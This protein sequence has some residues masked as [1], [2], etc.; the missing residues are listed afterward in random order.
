MSDAIFI[1]MSRDVKKL[2]ER[3]P[4]TKAADIE[5]SMVAKHGAAETY[6]P[7]T[8]GVEFEAIPS[9]VETYE[10]DEM[11]NNA[12]PDDIA[13]LIQRYGDKRSF[14]S[15][16]DDW[17]DAERDDDNRRGWRREWN[18]SHGPIDVDTWLSDHPEPSR[19]DYE[20]DSDYDHDHEKW[21]S[22]K[23]E[24]EDEYLYWDRNNRDDYM[25]SSCRIG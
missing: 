21:A 13:Q 20:E 25:G 18:D 9:G 12:D 6:G 15:D 2:Q 5:K 22:E 14:K 11:I 19:Y 7:G 24:V 16:Y 8:F 10:M 4:F 23:D 3:I 17:L 1:G